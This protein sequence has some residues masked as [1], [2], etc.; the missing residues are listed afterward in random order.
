[1]TYEALVYRWSGRPDG[2]HPREGAV[3]EHHAAP[4]L[5]QAAGRAQRGAPVPSALPVPDQI[6]EAASRAATS[7]T[8]T[9]TAW[10]TPASP[11]ST[12]WRRSGTAPATARR[13]TGLPSRR[14]DPDRPRGRTRPWPGVRSRPPQPFTRNHA[15][16]P[17]RS[18]T[19]RTDRRRP[20]PQHT[21][22]PESVN[23]PDRLLSS[24]QIP[25]P[26]RSAAVAA[27][28][29]AWPRGIASPPTHSNFSDSGSP[30]KRPTACHT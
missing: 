25:P 17:G 8:G 7:W 19:R 9:R 5:A 15:G 3:A 28:R 27:A 20:T 10:P 23:G 13:Y 26:T 4:V 18:P 22:L 11:R 12:S 16:W 14:A 29:Q 30:L 1:M 2:D 6:E 24:V 21:S